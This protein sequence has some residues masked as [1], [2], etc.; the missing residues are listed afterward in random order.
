MASADVLMGVDVGTTKVAAVI[1]GRGA[2]MAILGAASTP[3]QGLRRG[4]VVDVEETIRAIAQAVSQ[5]Q[6]MA[7]VEVDS[8]WVGVTGQHMACLRTRAELVL[9]RAHRTVTPADIEKVTE[10]ARGSV[11][12]APDRQ[13]LHVL[14]RSYWVD[15]EPRVRNP[16]GLAA[17]RIAVDAH[18]VTASRVALENVVRCVEGAGL[19]VAGLVAEPLATATA[20]PATVGPTAAARW[21]KSR[22]CTF[23]GWFIFAAPSTKRLV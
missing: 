2:A 22:R 1:G 18:V 4:T 9:P 19:G 8:A 7:G 21:R 17:G 20:D 14:P 3:C 16:V 11:P 23:A 12:V 15:D 10:A 5:A 13:L 6:Q